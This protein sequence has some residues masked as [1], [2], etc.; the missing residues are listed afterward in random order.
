MIKNKKIRILSVF[1][2]AL[3]VAF[4]A[5][6][7]DLPKID[8]EKDIQTMNNNDDIIIDTPIEPP[9]ENPPVEEIPEEIPVEIP[10]EPII[11]EILDKVSFIPEPLTDNLLNIAKIHN[12]IGMSLVVVKNNQVMNT[13]AYGYQDKENNVE[14][15][16]DS[17][18]RIAAISELISSIAVMKLSEEAK[19]NLDEDISNYLTFKT[20]VKA[21]NDIPVTMRHI[22]THTASLSDY[23]TYDKIITGEIEYQPL[24]EII[25]LDGK[26]YNNNN[27]YGIKPGTT[28]SHSN[29]GGG[30]IGCVTSAI[31]TL[32]FYE[33][34]NEILFTPLN[35]DA[36]YLSNG[37]KEP[38]KISNIYK[39]NNLNY[40]LTEMNAFAE[41]IK[42]INPAD[43]Y[44][45]SQGNL[46]I[47]AID[48]S[49]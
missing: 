20:G 31:T 40:N 41:S 30:I 34:M 19:F 28:F 17:K 6:L 8:E 24:S 37:I 11:P 29:F 27:F 4:I 18:L 48:L 42:E 38:V 49:R 14:F 10:V 13:Y 44:R 33:Y 3:L 25:G 7:C 16:V 21:F 23:N 26:Y 1:I 32:P 15:S 9:V 47:S 43:N 39:Q 22:M 45:I 46:F 36:S 12:V 5:F 35:L 2:S